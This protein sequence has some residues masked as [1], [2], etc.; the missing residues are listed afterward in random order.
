M[1]G[2]VYR[3]GWFLAPVVDYWGEGGV[4]MHGERSK[5]EECRWWVYSAV[6]GG[7]SSSPLVSV[8]PKCVQQARGST[9]P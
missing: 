9:W 3:L 7:A 6:F 2:V 4:G 5:W 1:G 8:N